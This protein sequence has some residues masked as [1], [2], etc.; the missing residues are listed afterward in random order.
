MKNFNVLVITLSGLGFLGFGILLLCWP[1]MALPGLGIQAASDQAEVELRAMYG[2]LEIGLGIL[3]LGCFAPERQRFGLQLTLAAYAGLGL[4]RA[5]CML[6]I[7][8]AT[9]FLWFALAWEGIFAGLALLALRSK[10]A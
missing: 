2:G 7:G 4:A 1:D 9:P 6:G 10:T 8:V 5:A 3:L